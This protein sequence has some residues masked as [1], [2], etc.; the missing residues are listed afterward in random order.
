MKTPAL[1]P[2]GLGEL[3]LVSGASTSSQ[4]GWSCGYLPGNSPDCRPSVGWLPC[5]VVVFFPIIAQISDLHTVCFGEKTL[6]NLISKILM[7]TL[8]AWTQ[9]SGKING[10]SRFKHWKWVLAP[11]IWYYMSSRCDLGVLMLPGIEVKCP[12]LLP[13][14]SA[15][16]NREGGQRGTYTSLHS[17][18][19]KLV[20]ANPP[21][22]SA[23]KRKL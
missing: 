23:T 12:A 7:V 19:P 13:F 21:R 11:T 15:K 2:L 18:N 1:L 9:D 3:W 14:F 10:R 20:S 5:T 8:V 17:S 16:I 22:C 4:A 6:T